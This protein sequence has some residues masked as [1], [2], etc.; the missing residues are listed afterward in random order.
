MKKILP[1]LAILLCMA[2]TPV[3]A[4]LGALIHQTVNVFY[5]GSLLYKDGHTEEYRFVAVPKSNQASIDVSNEGKNKG[6]I[7]VDVNELIAVTIWHEDFPEKKTTLYHLDADSYAMLPGNVWGKPIASS[8]WGTLYKCHTT[9]TMD[10][11]TGELEGDI[12]IVDN[13]P[14]PTYCY[15]QCKDFEKAQILCAIFYQLR[16]FGGQRIE[17]KKITWARYDKKKIAKIFASNPEIVA[18]IQ[19]KKLLASDIQ[20]ILDEMAR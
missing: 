8:A 11:K 19:T 3:Q 4:Q 18:Q 10:T 6:I 9:Y 16:G 1:I 5:C 20:F 14:N 2:A 15:L 13:A 7:H 12:Y 17:E